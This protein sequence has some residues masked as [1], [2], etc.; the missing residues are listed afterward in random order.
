MTSARNA[1]RVAAGTA[2]DRLETGVPNLD[3]V[4]S[5]GL[6]QGASAMIIGRPGT[7]KTI[8]AQQ[9]A[10][11]LAK[12]GDA[13]LYLTGYS[14][15]HDK[16]LIHNRELSY[17]E[18]NL[19]GDRIVL[20][21]LPDLLQRGAAETEAAIVAMVLSQRPTLVVLDGFRSMRGLLGDVQQAAQLLYSLS[22]KLAVLGATLL[23]LVEGDP[24]DHERYP[25]LAVCDVILSL[26]R[27]RDGSRHRRLLEVLKVRGTAPLQGVHP[28]VIDGDGVSLYP[29]FEALVRPSSVDW[30]PGRACFG[31]PKLDESIGGGLTTGTTT[32]VAGTPGTGKT[33]LGLHLIAEGHRRDEPTLFLG[34]MESAA[35]LRDKARVFGLDLAAAEATGHT[36]LMNLPA[37]DLEADQVAWALREDIERRGVRR[38]VVDSVAELERGLA[39]QDRKPEFLAALVSYLRGRNVTTYLTLDVSTIV[40]PELNFVSTPLSVL[41]ENLVL[42]RQTEYLGALRRILLILKMRFCAYDSALREYTITPNKGFELLGPAPAAEGL[43]TGGA[44]PLREN[45]PKPPP[46]S[47]PGR[48]GH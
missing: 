30:Q 28:F 2:S 9:I 44:R 19:I 35:Q 23:V 36:R 21:S 7:G 32:L 33:L 18:S 37:F 3:L 31:I 38:L 29:R 10:F 12:R 43:L 20:G 26:E 1:P 34:F 22:A 25:E 39:S 14:E 24:D 42:L 6:L 13:T 41:A 27:R 5:G 40:G 11:Y 16:L 4:L 46:R 45:R 8:L 15:S 17:F 47:R 48:R